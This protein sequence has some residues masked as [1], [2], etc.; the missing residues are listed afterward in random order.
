MGLNPCYFAMTGDKIQM[1]KFVVHD[2]R[3]GHTYSTPGTITGFDGETTSTLDVQGTSHPE[4]ITATGSD[5]CILTGNGNDMVNALGTSG[6]VFIHAGTGNDSLWT[7]PIA[8]TTIAAN[9]N[10]SLK[11]ITDLV[12]N[13]HPGD[14]FLV[15]GKCAV[16]TPHSVYM[17]AGLE[18]T[19]PGKASLYIDFTGVKPS[20]LVANTINRMGTETMIYMH[21]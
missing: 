2:L 1:N 21:S 14:Y 18:V 5:L 12:S 19:V 6:N 4:A 3:T 20:Q 13:F 17:G 7:S 15:Y 11:T 10:T 9:V 16:T 8:T